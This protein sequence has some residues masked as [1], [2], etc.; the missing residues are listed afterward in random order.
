LILHNFIIYFHKKVWVDVAV[1]IPW[2][3]RFSGSRTNNSI[4]K[5]GFCEPYDSGG[6]V[7][8]NNVRSW[9][10]NQVSVRGPELE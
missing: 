8:I 3:E 10:A 5:Q 9:V 6:L 4:T 7:L 2:D 1:L